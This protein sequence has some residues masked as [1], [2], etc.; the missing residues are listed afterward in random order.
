MTVLDLIKSAYTLLNINAVNDSLSTPEANAALQ[1]LNMMVDQ[2]TTEQFLLYA[3]KQYNFAVSANTITYTIGPSGT[4]DTTTDDRPT[5]IESAFCRVTNSTT[6]IDFVMKQITN[7]TYEELP[8]KGFG[9]SYPTHFMYVP[10]YPLGSISLYPMPSQALYAYFNCWMQFS[11]FASLT[12]TIELPPGY[13]IALRYGLAAELIPQYGIP[14]PKASF[15]LKRAEELKDALRP[16]NSEPRIMK[17]D[18][19]LTAGS[20]RF[21][22]FSGWPSP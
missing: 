5:R 13:A 10:S 9:T 7:K 14:E 20:G 16:L 4:W 17:F 19:A 1:Y 11:S 15:I 8:L 18:S 21:N 2:W 3:I 22:V 12:T 6:A